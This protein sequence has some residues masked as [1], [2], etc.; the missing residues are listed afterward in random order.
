MVRVRNIL[1]AIVGV[2]LA[3][4]DTEEDQKAYLSGLQGGRAVKMTD[5]GLELCGADGKGY[6]GVLAREVDYGCVNWSSGMAANSAPVVAGGAE[7]ETTEYNGNLKVGDELGFDA[8]GKFKKGTGAGVV[9]DIIDDSTI[10]AL[11]K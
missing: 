1:G 11:V 8:D 6:I 2:A 10:L 9:L 3:V 7:I 4:K 5:K